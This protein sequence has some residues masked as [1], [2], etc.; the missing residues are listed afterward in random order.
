MRCLACNAEL[1]DYEAVRKDIHGQYID[2][3][4]NCYS[5]IKDDLLS[6]DRKGLLLEEGIIPDFTEWSED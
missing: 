2:M 5:T 3:C 4:N 1:S 6:T